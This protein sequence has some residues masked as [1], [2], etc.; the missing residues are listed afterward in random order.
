MRIREDGSDVVKDQV[1]S[2]ATLVFDGFVRHGGPLDLHYL[3]EVGRMGQAR[4]ISRRW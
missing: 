3:T 2:D 1:G 4:K